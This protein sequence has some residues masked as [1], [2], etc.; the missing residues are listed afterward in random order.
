MAFDDP[1]IMPTVPENVLDV[2]ENPF[3]AET[4]PAIIMA[5]GLL[6][7]ADLTLI[8]VKVVGIDFIV[9]VYVV[10]KTTFKRKGIWKL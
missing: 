8:G 6:I 9:A 1:K 10:P 5:F 3:G 4:L 7:K 2:H